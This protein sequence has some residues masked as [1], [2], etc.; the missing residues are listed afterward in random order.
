[1][2]KPMNRPF[3]ADAVGGGG[4]HYPGLRPGLYEPGLQPGKTD[5]SLGS[6]RSAE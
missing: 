5:W 1:M 3:R 6:M 4:C 2:T